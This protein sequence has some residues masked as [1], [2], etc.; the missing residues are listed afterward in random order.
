[1]C[2]ARAWLS[3]LPSQVWLSNE[4]LTVIGSQRVFED[5]TTVKLWPKHFVPSPRSQSRLITSGRPDSGI[6]VT[7]RGNLPSIRPCASFITPLIHT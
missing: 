6:V 7:R 5:V 3:V 1:M 2:P 4:L